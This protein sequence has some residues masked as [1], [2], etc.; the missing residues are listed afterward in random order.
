MGRVGLWPTYALSDEDVDE[1]VD[2]PY[3]G[4]SFAV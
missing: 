1:H 4:S 3:R 2:P